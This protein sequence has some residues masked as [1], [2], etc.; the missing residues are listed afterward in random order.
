[1][2]R[3]LSLFFINMCLLQK[4]HSIR[5]IV[6]VSCQEIMSNRPLG[7]MNSIEYLERFWIDG[8]GGIAA[9]V[10]PILTQAHDFKNEDFDLL[11]IRDLLLDQLVSMTPFTNAARN[12]FAK[13]F[14]SNL[15]CFDE[16]Q[17]PIPS[18]YNDQTTKAKELRLILQYSVMPIVK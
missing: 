14:A 1:M 6:A 17:R 15:L 7:V 4:A 18:I 2:A 16:Y 5:F 12:N 3:T 9:S 13:Q 10:Q 8:L 11:S